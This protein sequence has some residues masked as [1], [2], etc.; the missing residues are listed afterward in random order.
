MGL[1]SRRGDA[2]DDAL[3][4]LSRSRADR[5]RRAVLAELAAL[6]PAGPAPVDGGSVVVGPRGVVR[7]SE[8]AQHAAVQPEDAWPGLVREYLAVVTTPPAAPVDLAGVRDVVLPRLLPADG[9]LDGAEAGHPAEGLVV[10]FCLD[11]PDRVQ[12]LDDLAPLGGLEAVAP[13]ADANLRRLPAPEH[14]RLDPGSET[15]VHV[16]TADDF[17]VATRLLAADDVLAGAGVPRSRHGLLAVVPS[18]HVLALHPVA[19]AGVVGAVTTLL[20]VARQEHHGPGAVSGDVYWRDADG[21][22]QRINARAEDGRVH[23]VVAGGFA[24]VMAAVR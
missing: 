13:L 19:G 20:A 1:F 17:H 15:E 9:H 23:V 24:D 11:L 8:L 14:H 16:F 5:L 21:R 2:P 12:L 4:V 7:L 6:D 3:P 10:R 22:L 18:R